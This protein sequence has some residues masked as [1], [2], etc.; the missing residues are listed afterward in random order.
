MKSSRLLL[1]AALAAGSLAAGSLRAQR[2]VVSPQAYAQREAPSSNAFPFGSVSTQFRYLNVHDDLAG[3]PRT[4]LAFALR[5]GATTSTTT[6]GASTVTLD[7]F[8]STAATTG[9]TV[10]VTFDNNHGADKL[11]VLTNR[12]ISFPAAGTGVIPYPFLYQ[13]PLDVPFTFAGAG[14]LCWEVRI[15]GRTNATSNFHDYV[16]GSSTNP[17]MAVSRYG[18]GC[19]ATGRSGFF[20]LTG[21]SS[22]D[23]PNRSGQVTATT[24][25]GP[26]NAP[27][28]YVVGG[29]STSYGGLPLPL[30]LPGTTGGPSGPCYLNT[31]LLTSLGATL[32]SAGAVTFRV[33]VPLLPFLGGLNLFGQAFAVDA[34]ANSF[35]LVG[36]NGIDHQIVAP[37]TL[38][39]GGRVYASGSLGATGT[40]GASQ[41]LVVQFTTT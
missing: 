2:T 39:P 23:W 8:M 1:A 14:G 26:A 15:T 10:D 13:L 7:G 35:G 32:S 9:A 20:A 41:T 31:D 29:S 38:P 6:I 22:V 40:L 18:D 27:A 28:V 12:T 3:N 30:L 19:V 36:S 4:I 25:L 17:T 33:D 16:G 5:R 37:Y 21:G 34:A 11:Q 24:S